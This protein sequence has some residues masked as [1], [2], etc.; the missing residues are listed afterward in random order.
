MPAEIADVV[1]NQLIDPDLW[2][3][4]IR[5][6]VVMRYASLSSLTAAE[7]TAADGSLRSAGG[8]LYHRVAGAWVP[9]RKTPFVTVPVGDLVFDINWGGVSLAWCWYQDRGDG[10]VEGSLKAS[11]GTTSPTT[12]TVALGVHLPTTMPV[13]IADDMVCGDFRYYLQALGQWR[14]GHTIVSTGTTSGTRPRFTFALDSVSGAFGATP[15]VAVRTSDALEFS[16]RYRK[17]GS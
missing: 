16:F 1:D 11:A 8:E 2:G 6:R 15:T 5:D 3:N 13:P 4:P 17:A 10:W 9:Q 12:Q 7:P 14:I